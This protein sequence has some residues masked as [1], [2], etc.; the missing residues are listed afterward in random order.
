VPICRRRE[1]FTCS[2]RSSSSWRSITTTRPSSPWVSCWRP[3]FSTV[4]QRRVG[5]DTCP[6]RRSARSFWHTEETRTD[7]GG[8]LHEDLDRRGAPALALEAQATRL[9][10][11]VASQE[12]WELV[13]AFSDQMSGATTER[14]AFRRACRGEPVGSTC[15]SCTGWTASAARFRTGPS[16]SRSWTPPVSPFAPAPNG[17]TSPRAAGR[18][19]V[20]MLAVFAEFQA[21]HDHRARHRRYGAKSSQRR[22][23]FR[24][25]LMKHLAHQ[26][27]P[28][29]VIQLQHQLDRFCAYYN[30][31][32]PHRILGRRTPAQA[33]AARGKAVPRLAPVAVEGHHRVR[34]DRVDKTGTV[35]LPT[36]AACF[37]SGSAEPIPGPGC[38]YLSTTS[39]CGSSPRTES[40]SASSHHRPDEGLSTP[41]ATLGSSGMSRDNCPGMSRDTTGA[42]PGGVRPDLRK[43][44]RLSARLLIQ[45]VRGAR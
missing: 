35:T 27:T 2:H 14:P 3:S 20:Q 33:F 29:T 18:M 26:R 39:T 6:S 23:R 17:S 4:R 25:T 43:M 8:D 11:Y 30:G 16:C 21:G 1:R 31:V 9:P 45:P 13:R 44:A 42:P 40:C 15:C 7:E 22:E 19:R 5:L 10:S 36:A 38:S 32:R 28:A 37:T 12:G 34:R 24:Q 41:W